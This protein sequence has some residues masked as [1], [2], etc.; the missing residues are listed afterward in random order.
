MKQRRRTSGG[1]R[2]AA[3]GG[4][5]RLS[6]WRA[7]SPSDVEQQHGAASAAAL[8]RGG[9]FRWAPNRHLYAPKLGCIRH[10]VKLDGFTVTPPILTAIHPTEGSVNGDLRPTLGN[11]R[12]LPPWTLLRVLPQGV[13]TKAPR[14]AHRLHMISMASQ[15]RTECNTST[16][17]A[18]TTAATNQH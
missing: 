7:S 17:S 14:V 9:R 6:E 5:Q 18:T 11:W 16:S 10:A 8:A 1:A 15:S 12:P 4:A 3:A 13:Q 2:V